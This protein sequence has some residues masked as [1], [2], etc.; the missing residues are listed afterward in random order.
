[1]LHPTKTIST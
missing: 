1:M